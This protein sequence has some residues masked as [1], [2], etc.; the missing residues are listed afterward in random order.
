MSLRFHS[1]SGAHHHLAWEDQPLVGPIARP[2]RHA[3]S[4]LVLA[5]AFIA[6][7]LLGLLL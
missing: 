7:L 5:L 6:G 2:R 3:R 1:P 4:A